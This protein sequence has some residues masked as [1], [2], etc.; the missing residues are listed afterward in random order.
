MKNSELH[1]IVGAIQIATQCGQPFYR[2]TLSEQPD[3]T[4]DAGRPV[5]PVGRIHTAIKGD[6]GC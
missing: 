6:I 5:A 1:G 2:V 3:N 4:G